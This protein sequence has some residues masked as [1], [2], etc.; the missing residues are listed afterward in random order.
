MGHNFNEVHN[1]KDTDSIKWNPKLL[2]EWF[3]VKDVL[4]LWVADMDFRAHESI[5]KAIKDRAEHG[6]FG[7]CF[8][9]D[10]YYHS[11]INWFDQN[12]NWKIK[13]NW[14]VIIP[15]V[16]PAINMLIQAFSRPGDQII[17]QEPVYYPFKEGIL[18]NGRRPLKL[19][20]VDM[21]WILKI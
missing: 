20:M 13:K 4:P 1:R 21:R 18:A 16:V 7:Y 15:G 10:S 11:V 6:I 12:H 14:I 8:A 2:E 19:L 9:D 3:H 5:I 17:I